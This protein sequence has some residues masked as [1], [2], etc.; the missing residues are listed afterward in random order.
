[1][2]APKGRDPTLETYMYIRKTRMDVEHQL[3][4]LQAKR[5][6]DNL[7]PTERIALKHLRQQTDIII[8]PAD[9]GSA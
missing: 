7:P 5:H 6:Q 2:Y 8:K 9:T 3:S 4:N 1:M